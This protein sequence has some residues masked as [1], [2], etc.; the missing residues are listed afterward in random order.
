MG[1]PKTSWNKRL[2]EFIAR[3]L[4]VKLYELRICN[5]DPKD[6]KYANGAINRL[7]TTNIE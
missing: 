5:L 2:I 7:P 6:F 4:L 1:I 3:S